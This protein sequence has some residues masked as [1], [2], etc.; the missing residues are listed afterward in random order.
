MSKL[1][2]T[3]LSGV[4]DSHCHLQSLAQDQLEEILARARDRGVVGFLAPA[5]HL[6]E[7][8]FLLELCARHSDVWCALGVHPHEAKRWTRGS[9]ERLAELLALP[10]VVAVGECGLDFH[11][12]LS[13]RDRQLVAVVEQWELARE[14]G[15]PVVVHNRES[16][17][18][19]AN[20]V[21]KRPHLAGTR[22]VFHSFSGSDE[23]LGVVLEHGFSVG[24]SGMVTFRA[25]DNVRGALAATP[26]ERVLVETDSPYLAPVPHRGSTNEPGFVVEVAHRVASEK[27]LEPEQ[28]AQ[29]TTANFRA[30][31]PRV[32]TG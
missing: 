11:Y 20:E 22:G 4:I 5:V 15:L 12:D 6:D 19:M 32:G 29:L 17:E 9:Q 25:A 23:L 16:D 3:N 26:I 18:V 30:L 10:K 27:G 31:F 1:A 28:L 21:V 24:Y 2:G 14:L 13:P 8:D 7:A